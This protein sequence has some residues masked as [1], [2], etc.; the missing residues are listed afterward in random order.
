MVVHFGSDSRVL[1]VDEVPVI[2]QPAKGNVVGD[3]P[4]P[5]RVAL[6]PDQIESH[7]CVLWTILWLL[8][9]HAS[10]HFDVET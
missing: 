7:N 1:S 4:N 9:S 3:V 10:H 2:L 6:S 8:P 5:S